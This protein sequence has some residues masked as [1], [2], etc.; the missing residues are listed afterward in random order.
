M[1]AGLPL[2]KLASLAVKQAAKPVANVIKRGAKES[3]IF[4]KY[5]C[6]YPGQVY[7]R[8]E[9]RVR[10]RLM[11]HKGKIEVEPLRENAAVDLGAEMLGEVVVFSIGVAVLYAEYRRQKR[12]ETREE[13]KQQENFRN[14]QSR[15]E[16]LG[17]C[18]DK[19]NKETQR[20]NEIVRDIIEDKISKRK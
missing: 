16:E 2:F 9:F 1:V 10:M 6:Y 5:L 14:L 13:D 12:G 19:Q 3:E 15:V 18:L 20:L 7:H 8:L 4:K 17:L 11:G